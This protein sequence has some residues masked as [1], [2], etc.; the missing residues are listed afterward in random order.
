[1]FL[2]FLLECGLHVFAHLLQALTCLSQGLHRRN[3]PCIAEQDDQA[4]GMQVTAQC[5]L[6]TNGCKKWPV[7]GGSPPV[8]WIRRL[9]TFSDG[10][11]M[12]YPTKLTWGLQRIVLT[13]SQVG[14]FNPGAFRNLQLSALFVQKKAQG[15]GQSVILVFQSKS[16]P[17]ICPSRDCR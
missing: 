3:L 13:S 17:R 15:I 10:C 7:S 11:G 9:T 8:V 4:D 2:V 14:K 16:H 5:S 6:W 12:L 1:M